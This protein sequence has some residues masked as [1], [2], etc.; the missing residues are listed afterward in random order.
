MRRTWA[1]AGLHPHTQYQQGIRLRPKLNS[2]GGPHGALYLDI[3]EKSF[4][5]MW[6]PWF[7][8]QLLEEVE[9]R[10][11]VIWD[12]GRTH[13]SVEV[14]TIL[15]EP[16]TRLETRRFP[17]YAPELYPDDRVW[18]VLKYQRLANWCPKTEKE[19]RAGVERDLQS[20]QV[21]HKLVASFT[22]PSELPLPTLT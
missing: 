6:V 14:K 21:P 10:L 2:A 9:R 1:P 19:N 16:R 5:R 3:H 7:L 8:E 11:M 22:W 17:P 4:G 13:R 20:T 12:N 18:S 15:L